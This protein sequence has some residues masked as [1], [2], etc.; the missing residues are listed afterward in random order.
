MNITNA[1]PVVGSMTTD[2]GGFL[3]DKL[4]QHFLLADFGLKSKQLLWA[5]LAIFEVQRTEQA[6][7][8]LFIF[9]Y[10]EWKRYVRRL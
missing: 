2:L 4:L 1:T 3:G 6:A 8:Y 7:S 10:A 9:I 5:K